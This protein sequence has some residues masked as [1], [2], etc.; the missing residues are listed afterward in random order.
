MNHRARRMR[1]ECL[2]FSCFAFRMDSRRSTTA[3]ARQDLVSMQHTLASG[4]RA[5]KTRSEQLVTD[6]GRRRQPRLHILEVCVVRLRMC[7]TRRYY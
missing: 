5:A 7:A 4:P 6:A 1:T 2:P 3:C